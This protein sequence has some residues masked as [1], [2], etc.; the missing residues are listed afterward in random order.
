[1]FV[2]E[3]LTKKEIEEIFDQESKLVVNYLLK[4]VLF[5]QP[6]LLPG[7]KNV[8][9]QMTKEFL[10]NWVAQALDWKIIGAGNYPIDVYSE[11]DKIGADVKFLSAQTDKNGDFKKGISNETSL[12]QKFTS[13]G[14]NLDQLFKQKRKTEILNGW[15]DILIKKNSI[16]ISDYGLNHIYYFIFIRGGHSISLAIAKVNKEKISNIKI[17]KL[18]DTSA[19]ISGYID[20]KYGNVKIYKSKKRM[21]L[22]CNAKNLDDDGLLISWDFSENLKHQKP[23]RLREM[24]NNQVIFKKYISRKI[25]EFFNF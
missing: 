16:P 8:N 18:T 5:S 9:I 13:A 10:E 22:R 3:F 15:I 24:I 11:K 4:K 25:K 1:M 12:S 23:V 2:L 21:E 20:D 17:S 6:E 7:E 14:K 19:F